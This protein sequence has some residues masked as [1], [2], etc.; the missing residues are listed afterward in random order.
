MQEAYVMKKYVSFL[1]TCI[2]LAGCFSIS[3]FSWSTRTK[4]IPSVKITVNLG[5]ISVGDELSSN[6]ES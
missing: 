1:L 2:M 4:T 6:A 5:D 3:A